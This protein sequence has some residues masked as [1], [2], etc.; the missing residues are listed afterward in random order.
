MT[1]AF[2]EFKDRRRFVRVSIYAIT[3]YFCPLRDMEVGVQARISDISEGGA[4][5]AT[6]SEGIPP[7]ALVKMSFV[8]PGDESKFV[9]VEGRIRHTG[10]FEKDLFRSGVE[11]LKMKKKDLQAIHG[12]VAAH[13]KK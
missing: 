10:P 13:K 3:R 12:Y 7:E 9:T 5:L 6:F 2:S 4:L 1:Q 11:F 8:M